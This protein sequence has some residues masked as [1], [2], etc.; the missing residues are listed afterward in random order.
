M[1]PRNPEGLH[2]FLAFRDLV[3]GFYYWKVT[4]QQLF[5]LGKIKTKLLGQQPDALPTIKTFP[6]NAGKNYLALPR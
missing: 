2:Q 4:T 5:Y 3:T 6:K 1:P